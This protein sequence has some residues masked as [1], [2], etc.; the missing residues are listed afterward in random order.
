[1]MKQRN[2]SNQVEKK[3]VGMSRIKLRTESRM[4]DESVIVQSV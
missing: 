4:S 3:Q 1:M 2:F